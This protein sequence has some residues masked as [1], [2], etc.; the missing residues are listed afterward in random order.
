M[1]DDAAQEPMALLAGAETCLDRLGK[2]F[3]AQRLAD[4]RNVVAQYPNLAGDPIGEVT[5]S[6]STLLSRLIRAGR[7]DREAIAVHLRA[8]RLMLTQPP[9]SIDAGPMLTGLRAVSDLYAA[10]RAA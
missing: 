5:A 4:L 3:D 1:S 6:L 10:N 8:W 2:V 9:D 7:L